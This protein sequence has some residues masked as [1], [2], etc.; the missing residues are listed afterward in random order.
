MEYDQEKVHKINEA[1][2]NTIQAM[3]KAGFTHEYMEAQM[4]LQHTQLD[5]LVNACIRNPEQRQ[6]L[7]ND[8]CAMTLLL[9]GGLEKHIEE[10]VAA[11]Q[12]QKQK[13]H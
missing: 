9:L 11:A 12:A 13:V 1:M 2:F 5:L 8:F 10:I 7:V 4:A 6:Q 3:H